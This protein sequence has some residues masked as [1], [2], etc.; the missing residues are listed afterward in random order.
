MAKQHVDGK[1]K[2][3][4]E[5]YALSTCVW[6]KMTKTLLEKMDVGFDYVYVD[7]LKGE[8]KEKILEEVKKWNPKCSFPSLVV[9][10]NKC[11]VGYKE[12]EIKAAVEEG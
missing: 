2:G 9:H 1:D 10:G 11:V 4:I 8:E 3:T 12:D 6:C 7:Q 5:L